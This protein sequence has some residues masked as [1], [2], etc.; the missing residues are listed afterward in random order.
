MAKMS[1][2]KDH[3][4]A[5]E[6]VT[7][8]FGDGQAIQVDWQQLHELQDALRTAESEA[9]KAA[10]RHRSR[11]FDHAAAGLVAYTQEEPTRVGGF[12]GLMLHTPTGN[13]S[14]PWGPPVLLFSPYK[15]RYRHM[16]GQQA[17][18]SFTFTLNRQVTLGKAAWDDLDTLRGFAETMLTRH[19]DD[20]V[21]EA[22]LMDSQHTFQ[23]NRYREAVEF[24]DRASDLPTL[25]FD[26]L[27]TVGAERNLDIVPLQMLDPLTCRVV[28]L[29][30]LATVQP[31]TGRA[32]TAASIDGALRGSGLTPLPA[33]KA[34]TS[35]RASLRRVAGA[36][37]TKTVL[38]GALSHP[39][40]DMVLAGA[41][42]TAADGILVN[43]P[44][45]LTE[46]EALLPV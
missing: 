10:F 12:S 46:R 8:Q 28:E 22:V 34:L 24:I 6:Q 21:M 45:S 15:P 19:P 25:D 33:K 23:S 2:A 30:S 4:I 35:W 36:R 40:A 14:L 44:I 42:P 37:G 3:V 38:G 9:S 20:L 13:G 5:D 1:A 17:I 11:C 29:P 26:E 16:R 27:A 43:T 18:W 32:H 31:A 39:V 7:V 41:A